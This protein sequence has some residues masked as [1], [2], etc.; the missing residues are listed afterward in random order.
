MRKSCRSFQWSS[1]S[2]SAR[3]SSGRK[4]LKPSP[5]QHRHILQ[6]SH[7][8]TPLTATLPTQPGQEVF[9]VQQE[10]RVLLGPVVLHRSRWALPMASPRLP[11]QEAQ[12]HSLHEGAYGR[13]YI[14]LYQRPAKTKAHLVRKRSEQVEA[15]A[16][17][18]CLGKWK[19]MCLPATCSLHRLEVAF[20]VNTI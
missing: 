6:A 19:W 1:I 13:N 18:G 4:I 12:Q 11:G 14:E 8:G 20:L 10:E 7:S 3:C 16:L 5:H 15:E 2:R 17:D 9:K